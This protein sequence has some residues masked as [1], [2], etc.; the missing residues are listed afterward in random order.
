M[1]D[2]FPEMK[3]D[4]T[5]TVVEAQSRA[6]G[7]NWVFEERDEDSEPESKQSQLCWFKQVQD[8]V[9][10]SVIKA[11]TGPC[12]RSDCCVS[13]E[14]QGGTMMG[15]SD[16]YNKDGL[17][18]IEDRNRFTVHLNCSS[19]DRGWELNQDGKIL[20]AVDAKTGQEIDK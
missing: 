17:L 1:P 11:V 5:K 4:I 2:Q 15:T 20:M 10:A 13:A 7:H 6:L 8:K 18:Q 12:E 14:M 16:H 19:C 3:F 9:P